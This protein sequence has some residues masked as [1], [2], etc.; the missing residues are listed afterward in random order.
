VNPVAGDVRDS[1][2]DITRARTLLGYAPLVSFEDGLRRTV[3]WYPRDGP[4]SLTPLALRRR[5]RVAPRPRGDFLRPVNPSLTPGAFR[6]R[7]FGGPC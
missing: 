2:A 1:Q 3:D 7:P 4:G 5:P 6:P